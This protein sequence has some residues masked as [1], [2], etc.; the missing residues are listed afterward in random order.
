VKQYKIHIFIFLGLGYLI[1]G[2]GLHG[3]DYAEIMKMQNFSNFQF[4]YPS[5]YIHEHYI[6]GLPA[7]YLLFWAYKFLGYENLI[8]YDLIKVLA[9]GICIFFIFK[10]LTNYF[11]T[12]R[13]LLG[14]ILFILFPLHD[15]TTYWYM[16]LVY[17]IP[18]ALLSYSCH[19]LLNNS[20]LKSFLY[21]LLGASFFYTSPPF[22]FGLGMVFA[23][24]RNYKKFLFFISPGILYVCYYFYIKIYF[25][26]AEKRIADSIDFVTF[27]KNFIVQ[28]ISSV[29]SYFGPSFFLKIFYAA[30]SIEFIS[31]IILSAIFTYL[32]KAKNG[33]ST[34]STYPKSLILSLFCVVFFSFVIFSITG[35]YSHSPFNLGNRT[36]IYTSFIA[37]ILIISFLPS[38]KGSLIF[39]SVFFLLPL[40]GLSDY[41]KDWNKYQKL[42]ITSI[43]QSTILADLPPESLV[44]ITDNIYH[45]LGAY[46]HVEFFSM[47]WNTRT[48]FNKYSSEESQFL[49]LTSYLI[50]TD[51]EV[52]DKKFSE[53]YQL[54]K[55]LFLYE[56]RTD[57]LIQISPLEL[58][59]LILN[60]KPAFRHWIQGLKGTR[61]E[62]LIIQLNPRLAYIF[63]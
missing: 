62:K 9:H 53:S 37:S 56:T 44:F 29:E 54:K 17:I 33:L 48:I 46:D 14:S 38:K 34:V 41:W 32:L 15:A 58:S 50:M 7:H 57:E 6:L 30:G 11:E 52:I 61:V 35:Y 47:N 21:G 19:H 3:D 26:F 43:D 1:L 55:N 63:K 31:I 12:D 22:V 13:A 45:K 16:A 18:A 4:F 42:I 40:F 39:L 36:L 24:Q 2:T 10:F 25:S 8:I 49:A 59:N 5:P 23:F 28:I 20:W 60:K 27:L 51:N